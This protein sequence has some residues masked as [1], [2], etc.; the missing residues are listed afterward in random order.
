MFASYRGSTNIA[1]FG[2]FLFYLKY[3]WMSPLLDNLN[4]FFDL[5]TFREPWMVYDTPITTLVNSL[6]SSSESAVNSTH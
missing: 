1:C 2:K 4:L 5:D 3:C 6:N